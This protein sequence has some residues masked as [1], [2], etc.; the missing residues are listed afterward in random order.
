MSP[1]SCSSGFIKTPNRKGLLRRILERGIATVEAVTPEPI[2]QTALGF[3]A[4]KHLF[5][6]NEICLFEALAGAGVQPLGGA[7]V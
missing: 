5:V 4:A 7:T 3:M 6:A 2:F 1:W